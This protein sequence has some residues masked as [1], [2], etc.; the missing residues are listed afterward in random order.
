MDPADF[1]LQKFNSSE[2]A[3]LE[4]FVARG[5]LAAE[6]LIEKGLDLAQNEFNK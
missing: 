1:V 2:G 3:D 6:K 4:D 5:A